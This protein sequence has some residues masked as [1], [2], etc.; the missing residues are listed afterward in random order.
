[1]HLLSSLKISASPVIPTLT[2]DGAGAHGEET[3]YGTSY[4]LLVEESRL[5]IH[6]EIS[7]MPAP[8]P[9]CPKSLKPSG[10]IPN[11]VLALHCLSD[12]LSISLF[13]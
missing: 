10:Y 3:D 12:Y 4:H 6:R 11:F 7:T 8:L 5:E 1:M 2:D 9:I 13:I